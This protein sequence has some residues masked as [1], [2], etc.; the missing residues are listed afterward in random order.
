MTSSATHSALS[1]IKRPNLADRNVLAS[2]LCLPDFMSVAIAAGRYVSRLGYPSRKPL[3]VTAANISPLHVTGVELHARKTPLQV[4]P[5][6]GFQRAVRLGWVRPGHRTERRG[7]D[8]T[9]KRKMVRARLPSIAK[10]LIQFECCADT[11]V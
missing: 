9:P 4:G 2:S 10:G 7:Q 3:H 11:T 5:E 6:R 1:K 8:D